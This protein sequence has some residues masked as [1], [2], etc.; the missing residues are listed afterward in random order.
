MSTEQIESTA[1]PDNDV[2]Q[3]GRASGPVDEISLL[4]LFAIIMKRKGLIVRTTVAAAF[5]AAVI[6]F[7][8]PNR[9]T[10]TTSL[11]PPQ[12]PQSLASALASQM[13]GAGGMLGAVAGG[14]LGLKNPNDIYIGMLKSRVVND[15]MIKRFDLKTVYRDKDTSDAR[16]DLQSATDIQNAKEG[17]I[18]VSVEDKDRKRAA[19]MANAYVEELRK[20]TSSLAITEAGQRRLFFE[21]QLRKAKDDL[22]N[23]EVALKETQQKTGLIQLDNQAKAIIESVAAIRAQIATKEVQLQAM[24]Y[25]A[26]EQ[27]PDVL[28][29]REELAGLRAQ[30]AKLEKQQNSGGGDIQVPTGSVPEAGLQY[31]RA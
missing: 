18:T 19:D 4:E 6:S 7:I 27:N 29:L 12:Q 16:K 25:S 14:N 21:Q 24:Q 15:A 1:T 8:I 2:V 5:I 23:A 26:T 22:A 3:S 31:I 10:A 11:L 30:S 13:G 17:F 9:Y 28:T 20:L